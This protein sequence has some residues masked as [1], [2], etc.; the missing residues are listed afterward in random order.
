[1][2]EL[3]CSLVML[4]KTGTTSCDYRWA[5][6]PSMGPLK[7]DLAMVICKQGHAANLEDGGPSSLPQKASIEQ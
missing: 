5:E 4:K 6:I 1:M 2:I 7:T 3:E